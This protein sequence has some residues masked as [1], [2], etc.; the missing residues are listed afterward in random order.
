MK[1]EIIQTS[2]VNGVK[3]KSP[4][5]KDMVYKYYLLSRCQRIQL[6][7]FCFRFVHGQNGFVGKPL[8]AV[9]SLNACHGQMH[10]ALAVVKKVQSVSIWHKPRSIL[11]SNDDQSTNEIFH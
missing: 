2:G 11:E 3:E 5:N 9:H 4:Q 10:S 8:L 7:D 1:R 6:D